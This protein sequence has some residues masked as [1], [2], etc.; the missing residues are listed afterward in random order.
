MGSNGCPSKNWRSLATSSNGSLLVGATSGFALGT[1]NDN[2]NVSS[3][4]GSTWTAR[5]LA[6][7]YLAVAVSRQATL[8][9]A[10]G[11]YEYII[12]SADQGV[13]WTTQYG[14]PATQSWISLSVSGNGAVI[15]ART[16]ASTIYISTDSG[17]SWVPQ[18]GST[19]Q[20]SVAVSADGSF[21]VAAGASSTLWVST[22][23]GSN[24]IQSGAASNWNSVACSATSFRVV[25]GE[26][27]GYIWYG[28][29]VT[30]FPSE[31]PTNAPSFP[32]C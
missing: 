3:N 28:Q 29:Y 10:A 25:S 15:A 18:L 20:W 23:T 14:A 21:I 31:A 12:T 9:A 27:N 30:T 7:E 2:L 17:G 13:T 16:A 24:W 32:S 11:S 22:D 26:Y 6:I 8:I 19:L 5:A 1:H 4:G